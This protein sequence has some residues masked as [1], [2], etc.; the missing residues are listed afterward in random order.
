MRMTPMVG[1][2]IGSLRALGSL[3]DHAT[4]LQSA[5]QSVHGVFSRIESF[6]ATIGSFLPSWLKHGGG[7]AAATN[8]PSG[9]NL[10][11][12]QSY[13]P[14]ARSD[15]PTVLKAALNIDSRQLA[16]AVSYAMADM[17]ENS[18]NAPTGNGT[19]LA[20]MNGWNPGGI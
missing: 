1:P 12:Q 6:L 15:K 14:P 5:A 11:H 20:N 3:A 18:P 16:E 19:A 8:D 9:S 7:T 4:E 13:I 17:Y 2:L 10:F